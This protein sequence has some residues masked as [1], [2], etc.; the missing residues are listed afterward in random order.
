[1]TKPYDESA[2]VILEGLDPVKLRPGQFTRTDSPLHIVQEALDNA[3]DEALGGFATKITVTALPGNTVSIKDNGRGIPVGEHPEKKIPVVQAIFTILYSGGKFNKGQGGAYSFSGGLHGVGVSVTNALSS[4]LKAVVKRDGF[5]WSIGFADGNLAM[6]LTQGKKTK[7]TG[8]EIIITPNA[9]YFDSADIPFEELCKLLK[10]KAIIQPGLEV[11]F[12][13]ARVSPETT[14][15]FLYTDGLSQYLSEVAQ[16]EALTPALVGEHY[17]AADAEEFSEGEGLSWAFGWYDGAGVGSSSFVNSIPTPN[18]GTHV[19][20][21]RSAVFQG[22]KSYIEH[23]GLMPKGIKLSADDVFKNVQ[24]VISVKMLDPAFDNQTKDRLSSA[25][26]VKLV[27]KLV[28]QYFEPWLLRNV[29]YAKLL[30]GFGDQACAGASSFCHKGR[31]T[32]YQCSDH[33]SR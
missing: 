8:T 6:P 27:E 2:I 30:G 25:G 19:N 31:E 7:E 15:S 17:V 13:D 10:S 4:S 29:A 28:L 18:H 20:G 9:K 1:M 14:Q 11:L 12:V 24:F 16:G 33:A 23:H 21:L 3:V 26:A 32:S 5:E 22:L